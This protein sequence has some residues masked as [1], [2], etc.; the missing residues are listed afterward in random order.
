MTNTNEKKI[1][2]KEMFARVIE[3]V[4]DDAEM[5]AFLEHEI[6]LLN[7]KATSKNNKV[8]EETKELMDTIIK[9]VTAEPDRI[10][11][12]GELAKMLDRNPQKITPVLTKMVNAE[13]IEKIVDKRV[14]HYKAKA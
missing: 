7:R 9:I 10:F 4:Q 11:K 14:N 3:R 2:K 6:E 13:I 8:S 12:C 5:V 1:T